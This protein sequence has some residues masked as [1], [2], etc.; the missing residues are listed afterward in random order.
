M[1]AIM[2]DPLGI[3]HGFPGAAI[4]PARWVVGASS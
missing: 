4:S 3:H 2:G 1:T